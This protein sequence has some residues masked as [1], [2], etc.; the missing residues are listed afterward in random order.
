[1][2]AAET[3]DLDGRPIPISFS[4]LSSTACSKQA[5]RV[6]VAASLP[7]NAEVPAMSASRTSA[8]G[9]SASCNLQ[10]F[11]EI[12]SLHGDLQRTASGVEE[13]EIHEDAAG[14]GVIR[15]CSVEGLLIFVQ[16]N[17]YVD[18]TASLLYDIR[19]HCP[20]SSTGGYVVI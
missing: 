12:A 5:H 17:M 18:R 8:R 20:V 1:M 9:T 14:S 13:G 3:R 4:V 10:S 7:L 16:W 19:K 15:I 11:V 6:S 2:V